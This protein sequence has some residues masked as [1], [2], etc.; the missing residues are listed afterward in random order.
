MGTL[1]ILGHSGHFGHLWA[2][3]ALWTLMGTKVP[4]PPDY[5]DHFQSFALSNFTQ[6]RKV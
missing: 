5:L 3:W 2:L 4:G 6:A 1:G